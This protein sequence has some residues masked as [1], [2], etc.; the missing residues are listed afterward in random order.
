M[1][2]ICLLQ[3]KYFSFMDRVRTMV[4]PKHLGIFRL[5]DVTQLDDV[6]LNFEPS[7]LIEHGNL[8]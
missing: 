5:W 8:S 7:S 2:Q 6:R 3:M 1:F 4:F